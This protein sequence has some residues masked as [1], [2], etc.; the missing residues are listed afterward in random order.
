MAEVHGCSIPEDRY[1]WPEKHVWARPEPDGTVT[2]G[3]TDVAQ[4][5]ARTIISV[6]PRGVGRKVQRGKS[7]GTL[8]SGKWVGPVTS[9]ISGEIVAVNDAAI[10][11]PKLLNQ[12]PYGAGWFARLRPDDWENESQLLV[13]GPEAVEAYRKVLE[14]EG[15]SCS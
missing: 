15:I 2:I 14:Q 9:P 4:H 12:D 11:D 1:Y 6:T 13:T 3:I 7:A 10:A 5:L 8:E